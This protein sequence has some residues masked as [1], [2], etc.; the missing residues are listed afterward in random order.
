MITF[1]T[2]IFIDT[3]KKTGSI[4]LIISKQKFCFDHSSQT[5]LILL[6]ETVK[7]LKLRALFVK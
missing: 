3:K 2:Y 4:Q 5:T 1:L 6:M 7:L